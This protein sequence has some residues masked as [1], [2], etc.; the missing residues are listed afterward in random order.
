M[1]LSKLPMPG[2]ADSKDEDLL[3]AEEG[4]AAEKSPLADVPDEDLI[5]EVK[6]RNLQDAILEEEG[7]MEEPADMGDLPMP[8]AEV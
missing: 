8:D 7:D 5:A 1:D 3:A 4:M 2:P 6:A